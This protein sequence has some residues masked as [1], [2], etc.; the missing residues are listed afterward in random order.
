MIHQATRTIPYILTAL[1]LFDLSA[2]NSE[3]APR[4]K[5]EVVITIEGHAAGTNGTAMEQAKQDALR[6][7]VEQGGPT[8]QGR[9]RHHHRRPCGRN[10]WHRHGAG[11]AG[12]PA[13]GR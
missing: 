12:R 3:A 9:G 10:Q 4:A 1:C 7:A 6:K 11:Q 5:G 2:A 8:G 13:K